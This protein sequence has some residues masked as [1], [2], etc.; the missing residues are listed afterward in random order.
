[1]SRKAGQMPG[2]CESC[3]T[4]VS[5]GTEQALYERSEQKRSLRN[6]TAG[7]CGAA[8]GAEGFGVVS[9]WHLVSG[10]QT[11]RRDAAALREIPRASQPASEGPVVY[12]RSRGEA[13]LVSPRGFQKV[14]PLIICTLAKINSR[15]EFHEAGAAASKS[16]P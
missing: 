11:G 9:S 4:A 7:S 13:N 3:M 14:N 16:G 12:I 8:P 5:N 1:M 6:G 2:R 15:G 10:P